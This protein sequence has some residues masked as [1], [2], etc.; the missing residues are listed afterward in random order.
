[1][2]SS[3]DHSFVNSQVNG[4]IGFDSCLCDSSVCTLLSD[5]FVHEEV[6]LFTVAPSVA[7]WPI[8]YE[9]NIT[10]PLKYSEVRHDLTRVK[11]N[12]LF[13]VLGGR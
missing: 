6:E 1:M 7:N 2:L 3:Y 13:S 12:Y 11:W 9:L 8:C 10:K 4:G 5:A